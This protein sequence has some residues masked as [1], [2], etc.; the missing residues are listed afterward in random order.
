MAARKTFPSSTRPCGS[1]IRGGVVAF[2]RDL[3]VVSALQQRL[4]NAQQSME[5]D[6]SRLQYGEMRYR[7]LFQLSSEAVLIVDAV[8]GKIVESNPAADRLFGQ[9]TGKLAGQGLAEWFDEAGHG[10][11]AVP[12]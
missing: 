5:R 3:R 4:V 1:E 6:Y 2:G 8:T 7:V 11:G 9:E 10:G 12:C